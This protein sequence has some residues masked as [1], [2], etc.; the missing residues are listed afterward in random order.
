VPSTLP[1]SSTSKQGS[2]SAH[3]QGD[4][5]GDPSM[6]DA[7][8]KSKPGRRRRRTKKNRDNATLPTP[9]KDQPK[10]LSPVQEQSADADDLSL[11]DPPCV[12]STGG[13]K[14]F[15]VDIGAHQAL[16]NT[17]EAETTA[18]GLFAVPQ[19]GNS[20]STPLFVPSISFCYR[21]D[22]TSWIA[23]QASR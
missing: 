19:V 7:D 10:L 6:A 12:S 4:P 17:Q 22:T 14:G 1:P 8:E 13:S 9:L 16:S 15:S 23:S 21:V 5:T 18:Q 20:L 2:V 11:R 3:T